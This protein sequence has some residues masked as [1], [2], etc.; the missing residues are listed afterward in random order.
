LPLAGIAIRRDL[1]D[2]LAPVV[3]QALR[4]SVDYAFAH[5]NASREYVAAHAQEMDADVTRRHIKLYVN[6]YTRALDERAVQR[7]L[8]WADAGA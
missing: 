2:R 3:D 5:P 7:M 4:A 1:A 8:E 6:E